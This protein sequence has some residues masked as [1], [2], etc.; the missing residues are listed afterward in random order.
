MKTFEEFIVPWVMNSEPYSAKHMDIAWENPEIIRMMSNENLVPP[1]K[2]VVEAITKA[3]L[4]GNLYPGSGP[5]LRKKLGEKA[6]LTGENVVLGN[7]STDVINFVIATFVAP[8]DEVI[9]PDPTFSMYK[10]RVLINGG[11]PVIIPTHSEYTF[12]VQNMIKAIT[13]K[14]KLI[15][16]CS[17]N[18]PTG[19]LMREHHLIEILEQGVPVFYDE[20][21]YE[22]QDEVITRAGL[23][24]R[25]PNL[26]VNR[27]FSKAYGLA[28]FRL[29]YVLCDERLANY[30]NRVKIP[31]NVS[32]PTIAAALAQLEDEADLEYKRKVV[33]EGR[34]YIQEEIN[35]LPG[36]YAYPS[37]GNF[38]LIDAGILDKT[39]LELRDLMVEKGIFIRPMSG[40]HIGKGFFRVTVGQMEENRK[41]IE[42]FSELVEEINKYKK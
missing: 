31:W 2:K 9:I 13:E 14:T 8:G 27:T 15:F 22:L 40:A 30:F 1:S 23:I 4:Q 26:V 32:L 39:A 16:L 24:K 6:G 42:A 12:D 18:N 20:A 38:V 33:I 41:F 35:K 25:Y 7:G 17:P 36:I 10:S 34:K 37:Q 19:T 29:G 3:S 11:I 5:E 28:G 21:Y